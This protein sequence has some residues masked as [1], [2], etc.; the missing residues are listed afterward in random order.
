MREKLGI[1][2]RKHALEV[3]ILRDPAGN[4]VEVAGGSIRHLGSMDHDRVSSQSLTRN[5]WKSQYR[6][7]C[8][9][10][11]EVS[12][13]A[14]SGETIRHRSRLTLGRVILLLLRI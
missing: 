8:G 3:D 14:T 6:G 1:S 5:G 7:T 11:V 4:F 2:R 13:S 9:T 12:S 10:G